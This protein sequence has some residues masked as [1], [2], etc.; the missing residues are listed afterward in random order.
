MQPTSVQTPRIQLV[1]AVGSDHMGVFWYGYDLARQRPVR[2]HELVGPHAL[3]PPAMPPGFELVAQDGRVLVILPDAEPAAA[4]PTGAIPL[5]AAPAG[6]APLWAAPLGAAPAGAAVLGAAPAGAAPL[7]AAPL[8]AAPAG[9]LPPLADDGSKAARRSRR[10]GWLVGGIAGALSL[11][12]L[13]TVFLLSRDP[14]SAGGRPGEPVN[15]Q[16]S[17][18]SLGRCAVIERFSEDPTAEV[19]GYPTSCGNSFATHWKA[20]KIV[21]GVAREDVASRAAS[22]FAECH[23]ESEEPRLV[24]ASADGLVGKLICFD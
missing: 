23:G 21:D 7:W 5:G 3:S 9:A 16:L 10:V 14:V 4:M 12:V 2:I 17:W 8:G 18:V 11:A 24:W 22:S 19:N 6:A 15:L 20:S 1:N 13:A